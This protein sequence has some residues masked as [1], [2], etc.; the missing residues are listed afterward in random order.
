MMQ[1]DLFTSES[2]AKRTTPPAATAF[3]KT[4]E[5]IYNKAAMLV[6]FTGQCRVI[7]RQSDADGADSIWDILACRQGTG[8]VMSDWIHNLPVPLMA[9]AIF[10]LPICLP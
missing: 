2:G 5:L 9:Q 4:H 7:W 8:A 10:P 6:P 3:V 1:R